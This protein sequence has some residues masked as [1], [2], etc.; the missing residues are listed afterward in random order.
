[1]RHCCIRLLTHH[2]ILISIVLK[3]KT[4]ITSGKCGFLQWQSLRIST[5][6]E[7]EDGYFKKTSKIDVIKTE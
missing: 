6:Q 5:N 1:M 3:R 7:L 4:A 2:K